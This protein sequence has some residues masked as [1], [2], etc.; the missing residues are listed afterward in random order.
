MNYITFIVDLRSKDSP[1]SLLLDEA[2]IEAQARTKTTW[3]PGCGCGENVVLR[4]GDV[5]TL[6]G[7]VRQ[8]NGCSTKNYRIKTLCATRTRTK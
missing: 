4:H 1:Q 3:L 8:K 7:E 5:I 6:F 2:A